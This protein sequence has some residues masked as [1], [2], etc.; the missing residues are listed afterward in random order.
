[1][2]LN[3]L[4]TWVL[5]TQNCLAQQD[6]NWC[7]GANAGINF[8]NP[9][10]FQ[11]FR[12][13]AYNS[14][15]NASISDENGELLFYVGFESN[16][17]KLFNKSHKALP[18]GDTL[19]VHGSMTNGLIILPFENNVYYLFQISEQFSVTD[20]PNNYCIQLYYTIIKKESDSL[21]VLNKNTLLLNGPL[22]EKMAAVRHANGKDWWILVHERRK[23]LASPCVN[24]FFKILISNNSI[25]IDSQNIGAM[26]CISGLSAGA[27]EMIF[28]KD[29]TQLASANWM[30]KKI[31]LFNFDRCKGELLNYRLV[32]DGTNNI[33]PYGCEFSSSGHIMYVS[34]TSGSGFG[35]NRYALYQYNL[36]ANNIP[37]SQVTIRIETDFYVQYGQVQRTPQ[38]QII[39]SN[40]YNNTHVFN[41]Y[42]QNISVIENPDS[43]GLACSFQR[44]SL[45]LGDS[46]RSSF[47]LPNMPNYNLGA[48]SIYQAF[49]GENQTLCSENTTVKGVFIGSPAVPGVQYQWSPPEG[50]DTLTK[51]HPFVIPDSS[52]W[53]Y[54][55]FTDTSIKYSCQS[56]T[57]SVFVEVKD[58]TVGVGSIKN[59]EGSIKIFPN[60]SDGIIHISIL[61]TQYS[62]LKTEIFD[63]S[64][65]LLQTFFNQPTL[66]ISAYATGLYLLRISLKD[67]TTTYRKVT[68]S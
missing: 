36:N 47:G 8:S 52:R 15:V 27:G 55:T 26:H 66:D 10:S 50:I 60:P 63:V 13:K 48:L 12:S 34:A 64:G 33:N 16:R 9:D 68:K 46:S 39:L 37:S 24:K 29:G 2:R 43:L 49:A 25:E 59:Q 42:N 38:G 5:L 67:G 14:E 22:E 62:L 65:K 30:E 4:I 54:V 45:Y 6:Y 23:D 28:S 44:Y 20:C 7:F 3:I 19:R 40:L 51:S 21:L 18:E 35:N 32:E 53:Y 11:V 31:E 58:C 56:K 41:Y 1:M 61:A 17:F 57:D